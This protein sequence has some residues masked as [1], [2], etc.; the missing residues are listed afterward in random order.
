M[1]KLAW[2]LPVYSEKVLTLRPNQ[3]L[4]FALCPKANAFTVCTLI[5]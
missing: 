2:K 3:R 1:K 5:C 4:V